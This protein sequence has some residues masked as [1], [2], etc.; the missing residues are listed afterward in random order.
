MARIFRKRGLRRDRNFSDI[1]NPNTA[2][3]NLLDGLVQQ[4]GERF[5]SADLDPIRGLAGTTISNSDFRNINDAA[6]KG[7]D[8][9]QPSA[10]Y[11]PIVTLQNR[12]DVAQFTTGDPQFFG[13]NKLTARYYLNEVINNEASEYENIVNRSDAQTF[14]NDEGDLVTSENFWE[15]GRFTFTSDLHPSLDDGL[16]CIEWN[17]HFRPSVSGRYT[18][19]IDTTGLYTFEFNAHSDDIN[20]VVSSFTSKKI[21]PLL[22]TVDADFTDGSNIITVADQVQFGESVIDQISVGDI[23]VSD[24][25]PF[26]D[27]ENN[28]IEVEN[29]N[30]STREVS[31]S[32]TITEISGTNSIDISARFGENKRLEYRTDVLEQYQAYPIRI[33]FLWIDGFSPEDLNPTEEMTKRIDVSISSPIQN[34]GSFNYKLLYSENYRNFPEVGT[35]GAGDFYEFFVERVPPGGTRLVLDNEGSIGA[36][37]G[38]DDYQN[39]L[40]RDTVS[41]VY[42]PPQNYSDA[43]YSQGL[44]FSEG[45]IT[46]TTSNTDGISVG[47][48]VLGNNVDDGT[49]VDDIVQNDA[50]IVNTP[51]LSGSGSQTFY[52][53]DHQ[54]LKG[55]ETGVSSDIATY[56][57]LILGIAPDSI[58]DFSEGDVVVA[59]GATTS[60]GV[61]ARIEAIIESPEDP[62]VYALQLSRNLDGDIPS[63]PQDFVLVYH[64]TSLIDRSL[65]TFCSDAIAAETTS[66]ASAGD[67]TL[68]VDT[69]NA[70]DYNGDPAT[71]SVD[72]F[73]YFGDR[74][75][76]GTTIVAFNSDG[77]LEL[78]DAI[79]QEIPSNQTLAFSSVNEDKGMCFRPRDTSPPFIAT[80]NG[81]RTTTT[82]P[83]M[84]VVSSNGELR[85]R[86]LYLN[87]DSGVGSATGQEVSDFQIPIKD[88]NGDSFNILTVKK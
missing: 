38:I 11:Q 76:D 50:V 22:E 20:P 80:E 10:V 59:P 13:G 69:D 23:V 12:I 35:E 17:G 21:V 27:P 32:E 25:A 78:S 42:E 75:P 58:S 88:A 85:F 3:N 36:E 40:S 19:R 67:T 15:D 62:N 84:R 49:V 55:Y 28:P 18:F 37:T 14:V 63:A 48:T 70:R 5:V 64:S 74:I 87:S 54:G 61:W 9:T 56:P 51:I 45:G 4:S 57:D 33:R 26:D 82:Y 7:L 86:E 83:N 29:V 41:L 79:E 60:S 30:Y 34:I 43:V 8:R 81:L 46:L 1:Q 47:N 66:F 52:F 2:L 6:L 44:G 71:I 53:A 31:L 16:G 68:D 24:F 39:L 73:V 72:D 77:S 65:D